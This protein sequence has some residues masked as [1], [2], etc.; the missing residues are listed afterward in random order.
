MKHLYESSATDKLNNRENVFCTHLIKE[1]T[2]Y[3]Q[4]GIQLQTI[5]LSILSISCL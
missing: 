1:Q 2:C 5:F 3:Q 4:T